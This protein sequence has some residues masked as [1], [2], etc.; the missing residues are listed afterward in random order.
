[1]AALRIPFVR[2][3][4]VGRSAATMGMQFVSV[5]VGWE[6]YERTGDPWALGLVGAVQVAPVLVLML[7]AGNVADRFAR[8]NIAVAAHAVL[9]L[10]TIGLAAVSWL[11]GAVELVFALLLLGGVAR[12]FAQPAT[13][14]LLPQL[15]EPRQFANANAWLISSFQLASISGPAIGGILIAVSGAATSSYLAAAIG[16][17]VFIGTLMTLPAVRPPPG[18]G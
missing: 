15:L 2:A 11:G 5:A 10:E 18:A 3:Y 14:T 12:A 9:M 8:R 4:I 17:L 7:P 16:N 13:S 6:L 1:L